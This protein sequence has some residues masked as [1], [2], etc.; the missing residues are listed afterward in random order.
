MRVP[1]ENCLA[2]FPC[3]TFILCISS[4]ISFFQ[5][6]LPFGH[7]EWTPFVATK[8]PWTPLTP[9]YGCEEFGIPVPRKNAEAWRHFDVV[10]L[11]KQNYASLTQGNGVELTLSE[12]MVSD[13]KDKLIRSGGWLEDAACRARLVYI[14]GRFAPQL[15]KSAEIAKNVQDIEKLSDTTKQW[16]SRL[17]DGFT[18]ELVVP[19]PFN[20]KMMT[21]YK[22]LS[23]PDHSMGDPYTQFAINTQHGTACFTALNAMFTGAIAYIHVPEG[24]QG[25]DEPVLVVNA[26]TKDGGAADGVDGVA[27]HPRCLVVAESNSTLSFV[28][29]T[30]DLD[31]EAKHYPKLFNGYTQVF[32]KEDANVSHSILEESGGIVTPQVDKNDR[33]IPKG[34]PRPRAIEAE[35]PALKDAHFDTVDVHVMGERGSYEGAL[36]SVG[37]SGM[38][39]FGVYIS[40]L[41]PAANARLS[42][43][44]LAGGL[45][46]SEV[47]TNIQ[48]IAQGT[49]SEQIQKT[50]LGGRANTSFRGRIRVEQSAQ[51]TDGNQLSRTVH[52]SDKSSAWN[53]PSLEV[54]ADDVKCTHG[55]T[56]TDLPEE[57]LLYLRSRGLDRTMARSL[58][59]FAFANEVCKVVHP[60]MSNALG[61]NEGLQK[62]LIERLENLVPQ[63]DR[64]VM[65]DFQ[66]V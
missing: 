59:M 42:G 10:G 12:A 44:S 18:D 66:S 14:N 39:R 36:M 54:V 20:G 63:G 64:A 8:L 40:L 56:V 46:N 37:G 22:K 48:H 2:C 47:K 38:I 5:Q 58:L 32:V 65:G 1:Q 9:A 31:T 16:L 11:V 17:T 19:V 28:Q 15:S 21:S 30:V 29:T 57:E 33:D 41:C 60:S 61:T 62:R 50:M 52:L 55:A 45:Q 43:F 51:Q 24:N 6:R 26:V 53:V 34:E 23:G 25:G 35:R 7:E 49:T 27:F 13:Y 4:L 3:F